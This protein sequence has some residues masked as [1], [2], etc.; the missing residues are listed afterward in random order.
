M[1][2]GYWGDRFLRASGEWAD[3][4]GF[5]LGAE[6]RFTLKVVDQGKGLYE[7]LNHHHQPI[8]CRVAGEVD[9]RRFDGT[10]DFRAKEFQFIKK[11][12]GFVIYNP[13]A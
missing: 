10:Q 3:L 7:L 1:D 4:K 13:W 8:A 9:L 12:N 6:A 5:N 11:G 2:G